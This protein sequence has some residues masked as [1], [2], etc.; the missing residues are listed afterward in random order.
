[1]RALGILR[2]VTSGIVARL[3]E[4]EEGSLPARAQGNAGA[5]RRRTRIV[6]ASGVGAT[7]TR[8]AAKY[9]I[10]GAGGTPSL[11]MLDIGVEELRLGGGFAKALGVS[12]VQWRERRHTFCR[13]RRF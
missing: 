13:S 3:L 6:F 2:P 12:A 11:T 4:T 5:A 8:A 9:R 1:M 7:A 10:G